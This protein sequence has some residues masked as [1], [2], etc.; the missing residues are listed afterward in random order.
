MSMKKIDPMQEIGS[1]CSKQDLATVALQLLPE[2]SVENAKFNTLIVA[3][4]NFKACI[5]RLNNAMIAKGNADEEAK[6]ACE[7]HS[8][9]LN[10]MKNCYNEWV[11]C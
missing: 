11:N 10:K 8:E 7:A 4:L 9:A 3:K 1:Y 6:A 5:E 2:I